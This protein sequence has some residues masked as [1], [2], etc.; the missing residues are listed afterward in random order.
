MSS[1]RP[2]G[3]LLA[4]PHFLSYTEL[5]RYDHL[6]RILLICPLKIKHILPSPTFFLVHFNIPTLVEKKVGLGMLGLDGVS[7]S[8][9][10]MRELLETLYTPRAICT[11]KE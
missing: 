4:A 2:A 3:S 8:Q 5:K 11:C 6:S 10:A 1:G 9:C 7:S